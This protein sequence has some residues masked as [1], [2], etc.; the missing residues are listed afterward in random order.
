MIVVAAGVLRRGD[1]FL[2]C[3]RNEGSHQEL[4]WEFPGGT[5][6]R[7]E[8]MPE[9]IRRELM[10]ELGIDTEVGPRLIVVHHAYSHFTID[11]HAHWARIV[12]G[13]PCA[14][15]CMDFAWVSPKS[16]RRY[17]FSAADLKIIDAIERSGLVRRRVSAKMLP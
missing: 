4:L 9:C 7:G 3:Q 15:H 10:E 8:T 17:P 2:L 6:E 1:K 12:K 5:R 14:I 11:L 16:L 13:R